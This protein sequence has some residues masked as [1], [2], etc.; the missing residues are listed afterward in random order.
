MQQK[1]EK[2]TKRYGPL[3]L[4]L[5]IHLVYEAVD[6]LGICRERGRGEGW[7]E[8]EREGEKVSKNMLIVCVIDSLT[9]LI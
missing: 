4:H 5:R 7:R 1:R 8:R 6:I 3:Q 9:I 2:E